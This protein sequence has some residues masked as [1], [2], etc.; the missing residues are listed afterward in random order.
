MAAARQLPVEQVA[1]LVAEYAQYAGALGQP[2]V[3]IV[4]L[5]LALDALQDTERN[6]RRT[7]RVPIRIAC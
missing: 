2:V 4:E 5:N 6:E 1:Q 3:N 7:L